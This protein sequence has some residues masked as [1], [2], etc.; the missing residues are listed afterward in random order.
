MRSAQRNKTY[1]VE[2]ANRSLPLVRTIVRDW[3]SLSAKVAERRER[4]AYL[5]A[6]RDPKVADVYGDEL[7]EVQASLDRAARRLDRYVGEL[8]QLGV[9]PFDANSGAVDFPTKIDGEEAVL[10]WEYGEPEV[11]YWRYHRDEIRR[12]LKP[13]PSAAVSDSGDL[14]FDADFDLDLE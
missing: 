9:R 8:L 2:E 1:T 12:P 5:M 10:S 11:A 14:D 4:I 6:G 13:E 7:D 3:V